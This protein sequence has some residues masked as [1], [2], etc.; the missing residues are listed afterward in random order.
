VIH[1]LLLEARIAVHPGVWIVPGL[2]AVLQLSGVIQPEGWLAP[3]EII[4]PVAYPVLIHSLLEQEKR[5]RTLEVLVAAPRCVTSVL[6]LRFLV[7]AFPLLAA[8]AAVARPGHWVIMLAPGIVLGAV[9]LLVSLL[10]EQELGLALSLAWWSVSLAASMTG[11][12]V[13]GH[14]VGSWFFLALLRSSLTPEAILLR[15]WAQLGAGIV[16][17][18]ACALAADRYRYMRPR[19]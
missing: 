14:P 8:A 9:A 19:R 4:Y 12:G 11:S 2:L 16:L 15:K 3:L 1:Y 7:M 6:L 10:W 18:A 5:W 13:L 17:L